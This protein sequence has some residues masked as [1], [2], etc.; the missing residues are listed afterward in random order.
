MNPYQQFSELRPSKK[1]VANLLE[2]KDFESVLEVGTQWGE[3]LVAIREKFPNKRI[4][5]VDADWDDVVSEAQKVTGLDIRIG[6][7]RELEFKDNEF[8]VVFT[9][10]LFCMMLVQDIEKGFRELVRVAKKYIILIE[11]ETDDFLGIVWNERVGANW[12]NM[13]KKYGMK[14]EREKIP[15]EVWDVN[16]WLEKGYTYVVNLEYGKGKRK[17]VSKGA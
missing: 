10:A 6:D 5:G 8:D 17:T 16:P 1:I 4:V 12:I 13:F 15:E 2:G 9:N 11:L 7:V 3:N 14:A